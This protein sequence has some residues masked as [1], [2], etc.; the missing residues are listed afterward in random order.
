[1]PMRWRWPPENSCGKRL[2]RARRQP[3]EVAA[4][5]A[6]MRAR[7]RRRRRRRGSRSGSMTM[8]STD[9]RGLSEPIR[10]LEDD[11]HRR[12]VSAA[13]RSASSARDVA[14]VE[15]GSS[16]AVGSIRR[17]SRRPSVDL[18]QPDSPTSPSVSPGAM[19]RRHAV[20]RAHRAAVCRRSECAA[21]GRGSACSRPAAS[22]ERRSRC[23]PAHRHGC[24]R[25][26]DRPDRIASGGMAARAG[27]RCA[28]R[29]R[30]CEAA[31]RAGGASGSGSV[32]GIGDQA[33]PVLLER[34]NAGEQAVG[35][36]MQRRVEQR[37]RP[38]TVPTMRPAYITSTR[39]ATSATTP[40]SWVMRMMAMPSSSR[41]SMQQIEDLRLD[42]DVE[43]RGGL[44]G[45]QQLAAGRRAPWRSSRAGACRRRAG[46]DSRRAAARPTGCRPAR[47]ARCARSRC[48]AGDR[49][50]CARTVSM[51]CS[52]MVN[53]GLSEVI[54]SWKIMDDAGAADA[55]HARPREQVGEL[56]A[57]EADA[58]QRRCAPAAAAAGP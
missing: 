19:S 25:R 1:M 11:L 9:M 14:A 56:F 37:L 10:V 57:V 36:G 18:P 15:A 6:T 26:R 55:L 43:R 34:G 20:D 38:A 33:M 46:A 47:A 13:A 41:R 17:T 30:G 27:R 52:P 39:S 23:R 42:G 51:I 24:R 53:T 54:G 58:R 12:G 48:G 32:P 7:R 50:S 8:S 29:Q 4:C 28:W 35:V 21:R 40:M 49:R 22:S 31:A 2:A 5:S 44:V 45:D 16:P 3:D